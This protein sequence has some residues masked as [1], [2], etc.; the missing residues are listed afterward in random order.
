MEGIALTTEFIGSV[1]AY[2]G[3]V[4]A[5]R[6]R[7]AGIACRR[8]GVPEGSLMVAERPGTRIP[9]VAPAFFREAPFPRDPHLQI[10]EKEAGTNRQDDSP[11]ME[12]SSWG[13]RWQGRESNRNGRATEGEDLYDDDK[14][15]L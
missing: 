12:S 13:T 2:L 5:S 7:G 14:A 3:G 9:A 10:Q 6:F 11:G 4:A 15:R 1:F 8:T